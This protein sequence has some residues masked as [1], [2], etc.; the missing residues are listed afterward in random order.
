MKSRRNR[1]KAVSEINVVPYIDVMLVLLLIFMI[2]TP[3]LSQGVDVD[4]PQASAQP[5][6]RQERE[7]IVVSVDANGQYYLNISN[8]PSEP[9][10][11]QALMEQVAGELEKVAQAN[12]KQQILVKGDKNIDYGKVMQAM[13]LLQKAGA[14]N[15]GLVTT[16]VGE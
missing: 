16:P 4:L 12:Q 3:L 1:R 15:V 11:P 8:T 10:T 7:P 14:S 13:V 9:I 5:I 2:T 6:S